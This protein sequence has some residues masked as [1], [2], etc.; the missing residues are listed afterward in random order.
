[1]K[2]INLIL[3]AVLLIAISSSFAQDMTIDSN[4]L[5]VEGNVEI[6]SGGIIFPDGTVLDNAYLNTNNGSVPGQPFQALQQ[7]ID[8]HQNQIDN[9]Q[10][11]PGPPGP[12]GEQGVQGPQGI[13]GLQGEQGTQGIQGLKGDKDTL[14]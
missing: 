14:E 11:I 4:G 1:M 10:L 3:V 5:T 2:K 13:Q 6:K 7:Q 12:Q 9:I 8:D